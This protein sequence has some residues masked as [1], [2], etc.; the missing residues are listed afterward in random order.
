MKGAK[1]LKQFIDGVQCGKGV[2][3]NMKFIKD[4][5]INNFKLI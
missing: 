1:Y 5:G 2:R 3:C 4:I